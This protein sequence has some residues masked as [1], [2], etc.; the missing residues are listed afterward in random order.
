MITAAIAVHVLMS[1]LCWWRRQKMYQRIDMGY[2]ESLPY[3][4]VALFGGWLIVPEMWHLSRYQKYLEVGDG[5]Q[6]EV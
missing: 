4:A 3:L 2:R 5:Q 6:G 1:L